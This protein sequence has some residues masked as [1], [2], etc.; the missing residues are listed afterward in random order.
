[1]INDGR[2][3]TKETHPL[4]FNHRSLLHD[5]DLV[6]QTIRIHISYLDWLG[7]VKPFIL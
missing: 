6:H 1:M 4:A 3:C 7:F 5:H 2:K